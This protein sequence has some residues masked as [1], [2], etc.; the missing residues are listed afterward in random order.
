MYL[1]MYVY[2]DVVHPKADMLFVGM[3]W[4]VSWPPWKHPEHLGSQRPEPC[5]HGLQDGPALWHAQHVDLPRFLGG[6]KIPP[7]L[8]PHTPMVWI[9]EA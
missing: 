3:L 6:S 5:H 8:A 1:Y 7:I 9:M 2:V 4:P